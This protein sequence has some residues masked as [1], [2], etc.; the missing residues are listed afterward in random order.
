LKVILVG[1]GQGDISG[2]EGR[3]QR[4]TRNPDESGLEPVGQ[5]D[6]QCNPPLRIVLDVDVHHHR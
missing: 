4:T 1:F 6:R 3:P 5:A 2:H